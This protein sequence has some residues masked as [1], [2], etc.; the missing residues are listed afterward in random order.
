MSFDPTIK[1]QEV[2]LEPNAFKF[3]SPFA[4]AISGP[5]MS[6]KS[7]FILSLLKNHKTMFDCAFQ[8]IIY[9][10]PSSLL[11]SSNA[12]FNEIKAIFP[13]A[14]LISGLPSIARL[15]LDLTGS[16]P[17]LLI[18]DDLQ[19]EF[20]NSIE[21]VHLLTAQINHF[22]ISCIFTLQ[23]YYGKSRFGKTLLRNVSLKELLRGKFERT[24]WGLKWMRS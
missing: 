17:T 19:T 12:Y 21:M 5:S 6:G 8:R 14:E 7:Y 3:K 22:Q 10:Q 2:N 1:V 24:C 13:S 4:L 20:L 9:C 15:H 18:M 23:S 16:P 11:H